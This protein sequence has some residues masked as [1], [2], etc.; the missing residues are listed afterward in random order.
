M[1]RAFDRTAEV[2][3]NLLGITPATAGSLDHLLI[4]EENHGPNM[5]RTPADPLD[6]GV[7]VDL[8]VDDTLRM[9]R[10][11]YWNTTAVNPAYID[12][13][14]PKNLRKDV[15]TIPFD[16]AILKSTTDDTGYQTLDSV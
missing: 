3:N 13:L 15:L 7:D 5:E 12:Y 8:D 11:G 2:V 16:L 4:D 6:I 1:D 9:A 10:A 14:N